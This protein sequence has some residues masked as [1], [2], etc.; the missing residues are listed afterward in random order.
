[1][2]KD[3]KTYHPKSRAEFGLDSKAYLAMRNYISKDFLWAAEHFSKLA[4]EI[5]DKHKGRS[6]FN[7]EHRAYVMNSILSS[8]AFLEAAI[9][10]LFQDAH[11]KHLVYL[12][13]LDQSTISILSD[14]WD[15]TEEDNKSFLSILDKYQM[16]LRFADKEPF[17]KGENPYQRTNLVIRIR[18]ELTHYKPMDLSEESTHKLDD[19]L[20]GKNFLPNKLMEGSGNNFFPDHALG[21]GCTEW[22]FESVKIFAD[23]FFSRMNI[24]PNY[25]IV[26]YEKLLGKKITPA[27]DHINIVVSD[28]ERSVKFYTEILGFEKTNSAHL[29]G[30]WIESIVGIKGV[31]ADVVFIVAPA[32]EPRIELLRYKFPIGESIPLNSLANTIGLRHI[33]LRVDDI[34]ASAKKLKDAGVRLLSEPVTVPTT[35]VTHDAGHKMLCYFYDPDGVL[36]EITEYK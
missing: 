30:D 25:Q 26:D 13:N 9:N 5:E 1:M 15:M 36:L 23:E 2:T 27:I 16:A 6:I 11:D 32:G 3:T 8:V 35:V 34:Q 12:E 28:L 22:C 31:V 4:G 20:K 21:K 29:E 33:A 10:E 14:F 19:I 18:N 7:I 17:L 24:K